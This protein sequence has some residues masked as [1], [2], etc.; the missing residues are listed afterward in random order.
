LSDYIHDLF[1]ASVIDVL[2]G[3]LSVMPRTIISKLV[4]VS[5]AGT[6][7][8]ILAIINAALPSGLVPLYTLVYNRTIE[9]D[10]EGGYN[11]LSL[12]LCIPPTL[13]LM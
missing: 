11:L 5:E 2:N 10:F 6:I 3:T 7:F 8:T 4:S 9:I 12:A 1:L 13:I